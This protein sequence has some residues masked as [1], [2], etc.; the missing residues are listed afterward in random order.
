[1]PLKTNQCRRGGAVWRRAV[2]SALVV[3]GAVWLM[4]A[5]A[6]PVTVSIKD[7]AYNPA[8]VRVKVGGSVT[9][10]NDDDRDHTVKATDGSFTSPSLSPGQT[11][12]RA[13]KTKGTIK[14]G[15]PYHPR[16]RGTVVVE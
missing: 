5:S 15:C 12:T 3:A 2:A 10:T 4:G 9:W 14:Y 13:F 16:E 11:F 7:I 8:E 6:E 1:M